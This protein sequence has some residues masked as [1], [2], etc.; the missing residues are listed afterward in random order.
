MDGP[1]AELTPGHIIVLVSDLKRS[2]DF[3]NRVELPAFRENS[4][5][6]IALIELRGGAH[7][8]LTDKEA[9]S[10]DGMFASRFGQRKEAF[11]LMIDSNAREDLETYRARL[12]DNGVPVS[13]LNDE[14]FF[15]HWFFSFED[16]DGN[17]VTV[18]TSHEIK[19]WD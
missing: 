2:I 15:G 19:Y 5:Y 8:I 6:P 14:L 16:P 10:R 7:V 1:T 4:Q 11:D 3:Y 9:A 12:I 17:L 13:D 18:Y